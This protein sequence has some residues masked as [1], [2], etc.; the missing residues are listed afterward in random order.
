M[1][2]SWADRKDNTGSA[3][4]AGNDP[5]QKAKGVVSAPADAGATASTEGPVMNA[6]SAATSPSPASSS[7][8][9]NVE[10]NSARLG[11]KKPGVVRIG[12]VR[13]MTQLGTASKAEAD[14][15]SEAVRNTFAEYLNG[16]TLEI[17]PLASRVTAQ[18]LV[19]ARQSECDYVLFATLVLKRAGD[20]SNPF[21]KALGNMASS[22]AANI[23]DAAASSVGRRSTTTAST[24]TSAADASAADPTASSAVGASA[25]FVVR[26]SA[27]NAAVTGIQTA[28]AL[29]SGIQAKMN[30]GSSISWRRCQARP[31]Y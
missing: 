5:E 24:P 6:S 25:G 10:T 28:T 15:A 4:T 29:A 23:G 26:S 8:S 27:R 1:M 22:S 31:R 19:E 16:P 3:N 30:S 13:P 14:T 20:A 11:P 2:D 12:I 7:G 18:A 17:V 9:G 21:G